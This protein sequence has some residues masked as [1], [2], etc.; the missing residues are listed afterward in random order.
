MRL[1]APPAD[2]FAE[3]LHHSAVGRAKPLPG[4]DHRVRDAV[5]LGIL[6]GR[7]RV[8]H[9]IFRALDDSHFR[10]C[11]WIGRAVFL[12]SREFYERGEI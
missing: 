12:L 10:T 8:L 5:V 3:C 4:V 9:R 1:L 2:A 11:W 7:L 6:E